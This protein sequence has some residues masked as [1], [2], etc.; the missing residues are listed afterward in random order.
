[1]EDNQLDLLK[2]QIQKLN[3]ELDKKDKEVQGYLEKI[4]NLEEELIE[5]HDLFSKPPSSPNLQNAIESKFRFELQEKD[6]EIRELKNRMGFLRKEKILFQRELD[7]IKKI[8]KT[9]V[10]SVEEIREKEKLANKLINL[11]TL[12]IELSKKLHRE[13]VLTNILKKKIEEKNTQIEQ[14]N[15][16]IQEI[17]Q[18]V[19]VK[20]LLEEGTITNAIRKGLNKELQKELNKS[21]KKIENLKKELSKYKKPKS[22]KIKQNIEIFE[23]KNKIRDLEKELEKK[24]KEIDELKFQQ[25]LFRISP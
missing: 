18:K 2:N 22:E 20:S 1:M 21:K 11:E 4:H 16:T 10:I 14:L 3:L 7:E 25:K 13:E 12:N 6:R 17:N 15:L 8:G 19:R 23:L 5:L 9:S 24:D